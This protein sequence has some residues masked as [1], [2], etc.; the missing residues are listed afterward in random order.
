MAQ[1]ESSDHPTH[2]HDMQLT[3]RTMLSSAGQAGAG[4]IGLSLFEQA[5]TAKAAPMPDSPAER[6]SKAMRMLWEEHVAWT[7]LYIVSFAAGLADTTAT[8]QRLLKNQVDIGNAI[9][10]FYGN[11]AG[12]QL[13]ALLKQHIR[14]RAKVVG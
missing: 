2:D 9:R 4:L 1:M 3:R 8:A 13:T 10:P 11:A 6:L 14:M 7:R 5:P 12:D